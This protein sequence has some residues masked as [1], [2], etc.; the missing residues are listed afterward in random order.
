MVR[1]SSKLDAF[2]KEFPFI[3]YYISNLDVRTAQVKRVDEELLNL[4]RYRVWHEEPLL[5][6]MYRWSRIFLLNAAGR[7]IEEVCKNESVWETLRRLIFFDR[8]RA[9]DICFIMVLSPEEYSNFFA[10]TWELTVHKLPKGRTMSSWLE[11]RRLAA[12]GELR[13]QTEVEG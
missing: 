10:S 5:V 11:E 6:P 8:A 9:D 3:Q 7:T 1:Y 4:T 2:K 13:T 12:E